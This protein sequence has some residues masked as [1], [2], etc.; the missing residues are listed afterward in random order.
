[1]V[2]GCRLVFSQ[3]RFIHEQ[4]ADLLGRLRANE[5]EQEPS[6]QE[7]QVTAALEHRLSVNFDQLTVRDAIKSLMDSLPD[8]KKVSMSFDLHPIRDMVDRDV[9]LVTLKAFNVRLRSVLDMMLRPL[10]LGWAQ[11]DHGIDITTRERADTSSVLRVYNV[12]DLIGGNR[13]APLTYRPWPWR[14]S[15]DVLGDLIEEMVAPNSW[16]GTG[17]SGEIA[18]FTGSGG[19]QRLVVR[20]RHSVHEDVRKLLTVLR[21]KPQQT[22]KSWAGRI[23]FAID[24]KRFRAALPQRVSV[25]LEKVPLPKALRE[26]SDQLPEASHVPIIL[27]RQ[28]MEAG[29]FKLDTPVTLH[30]ANTPLGKVLADLLDPIE[31][32]CAPSYYVAS[33]DALW[34][35]PR[36]AVHDLCITVVYEVTDLTSARSD[37]DAPGNRDELLERIVDLAPPQSWI[38]NGGPATARVVKFDRRWLVVRQTPPVQELIAEQLAC[39]RAE[40]VDQK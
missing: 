21:E 38:E 34:V 12:E 1:M 17:G 5:Q 18:S 28:L 40:K 19:R 37:A 11:T 32:T 29:R 4:V 39:L 31:I 22:D 25:D 36:S 3:P 9:Q 6:P 2:N 35:C 20:Q 27:D 8:D 15:L 26:I 14:S 30:V 16:Q 33:N 10:D 7:K 24:Q 13:D 23:L